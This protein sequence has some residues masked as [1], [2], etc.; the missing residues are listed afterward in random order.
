LARFVEAAES[1]QV[2]ATPVEQSGVKLRGLGGL[3]QRLPCVGR[4][5]ALGVAAL[6]VTKRGEL[7]QGLGRDGFGVPVAVG[8]VGEEGQRFLG[9]L[10]GGGH[11]ARSIEAGGQRQQGSGPGQRSD[12]VRPG[13]ENP[14]GTGEVVEWGPQPGDAVQAVASPRPWTVLPGSSQQKSSAAPR[15]S[16]SALRRVNHAYWPPL[17]ACGRAVS[18]RR[19]K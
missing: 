1:H 7:E 4:L 10:L 14:K 3:G 8:E 15:L 11:V 17:R 5:E 16:R 6:L 18:A 19:R 9:G 12:R 13:E 2:H